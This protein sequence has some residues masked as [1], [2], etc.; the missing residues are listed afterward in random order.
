MLFGFQDV[1]SEN[2]LVRVFL[3]RC[4]GLFVFQTPGW[5][6][7]RDDDAD[8]GEERPLRHRRQQNTQDGRPRPSDCVPVPTIN[9]RH[10]LQRQGGDHV[11]PR[12]RYC[13]SLSLMPHLVCLR[14]KST[15]AFGPSPLQ[16]SLQPGENVLTF[17]RS[18]S[19]SHPSGLLK[20]LFVLP[21]PSC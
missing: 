2:L 20:K 8:G 18:Q 14:F 7:G 5:R 1:H 19:F 15:R 17:H 9:T 13:H 11:F 10:P 16:P 21:I 12:K 6:A 3:I 4:S